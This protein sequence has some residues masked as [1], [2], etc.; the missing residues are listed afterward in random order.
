M[1]ASP[2]PETAAET[3]E[4]LMLQA[5]RGSTAAFAELFGRYK[6]P[7]FGFF[8]RRLA[9]PA[10]AEELTQD[11]FVALLRSSPDYQL[12]SLFRTFLY[13]IAF[14]ILTAHRRKSAFRAT[15]LQPWSAHREP[16]ADSTVEID[17]LLRNALHK[18]DRQEREILMLRE[19]EQLTYAEIAEL[20]DLPVN[21]VRSRLF[22][23]RT[24][25]RNLLG[26]R[27]ERV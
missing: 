4:E 16:F 19:F 12:T 6:Q 8:R 10:H 15:F 13:A 21:T 5:S 7:L 22:R 23:A 26:A 9:D 17:I 25:L 2:Q 24:A 18:L 27:K 20:L 11:T 3:D 14:K 1:T